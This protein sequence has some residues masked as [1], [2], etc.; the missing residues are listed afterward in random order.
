M[1]KHGMRQVDFL[2]IDIEGGELEALLGLDLNL[3][4][5]RLILLE[6]NT[7][8]AKDSLSSHMLS[9]GYCLLAQF[10]VNLM[11]EDTLTRES[12]GSQK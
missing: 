3:V 8:V 5:P 9:N 2:S 11:F 10:G 1:A 7:Q 12:S 4:R 6:A